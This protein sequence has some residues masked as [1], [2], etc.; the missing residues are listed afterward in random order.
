[1]KSAKPVVKK[2]I[3]IFSL[4]NLVCW[5]S[6]SQFYSTGQDPA[7]LQWRQ[8]KTRGYKLIYPTS[9]ESKAQ[10]LANIMDLLVKNE[11]NTLTAKVPIIPI[12]IHT[13]STVSNGLTI[14]APKRIEMYP[15]PPQNTYPEEWLEQL[16]I[17]EYR[18]V[19]QISKVNNGFSKFLYYLFGQQVTGGILG[20]YIPTWFLEGD[21]TVTETALSNA[22]RGRSAIF[23]SVLRAQIVETGIFPYDK[24]VLGSYR[25]FIPDQYSLGYY[26]V[27]QARKDYGIEIWN[28]AV[29][30]TAKYPFMIV[31]FSSGIHKI[32]HLTKTGLYKKTMEELRGKWKSQADSTTCT[33]FRW[34]TR[35]DKKN[36]PQY[37]HPLLLNDSIIIADKSSINDMNRFVTI[38]RRT[39]KERILFT[40]GSHIT[41]NTS[42]S[43]HLFVWLAQKPD[44][45]WQNRDYSNIMIYN[46]NTARNQELTHRSRFF[47]PV[48]SP[49]G[50]RIAAIQVNDNNQTSIDILQT[51]SGII[52]KNFI[53]E[54]YSQALSPNW[55]PDGT[56]IIFTWLD[57]RGETI[58]VLDVASGK[59]SNLLPFAFYEFSGTVHYFSHYVIFSIGLKGIENLYALDTISS[60]LFRVTSAKFAAF[61]PV[62]S[63]DNKTIIYSDYTSDGLMIAETAIDT[64]K[65]VPLEKV[66]DHSVKLFEVLAAQEKMNIQD[67]VNKRNICKMY[68]SEYFDLRK[69]SINGTIHPTGKYSKALNLLN[70]HRRAPASIDDGNLSI[71]PGISILFQNELSTSFASAGYRYNLNEQTG[72]L[73]ANFAY[74]GWYPVVDFQVGYGKRASYYI[75]K[76]SDNQIRFTW[77]ENTLNAKIYLPLNYSAGRYYRSIQPSIGTT[78]INVTHDGQTPEKFTRGLI[79]SVDYSLSASEY[80]QWIN[81]DMN[82]KWGQSFTINFRNSPFTVNNLGYILY[83]QTYLYFPGLF[84]HHSF[85]C[86]GGFQ[87]TDGNTTN[88]YHFADFMSYPRG[89]YNESDEKVYSLSFNYK[90]PLFYPDFSIGSLI[91]LKRFKA[92]LFFDYAEGRYKGLQNE[93]KS[94]GMDLTIDLHLLRFPIPFELGVRS[95]YFPESGSWGFEFLYSVNY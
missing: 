3:W 76:P 31:P 38:N 51:E 79:Q 80:L 4:L 34:I 15:C 35:R 66:N 71:L 53:I 36:Y 75:D 52:Q 9:F 2:Y 93:Y 82:P 39:G 40:P 22:G 86:Y 21:A 90:L 17:H 19:V 78:L 23:E 32:S 87:Q 92:N 69:D 45:R 33:Q 43:G 46:L 6:Y 63:S 20:M 68:Q 91:Y 84:K 50:K 58:S 88:S 12:I 59:I 42:L 14:W 16:A 62:F 95:I 7:F 27:G 30:K 28:S 8:I 1:M 65:W 72:T 47:S 44:Q 26:L 49:D 41:G 11:T 94:T 67:T 77:W 83:L 29:D 37:N 10:Y 56:K 73:Y 61:D 24:A 18:H 54:N 81:K 48:L 85:W 74:K 57:K 60:K 13:Q 70:P 25:S 5:Q 89:Y 64:S 55:S